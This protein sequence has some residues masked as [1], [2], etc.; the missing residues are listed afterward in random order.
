MKKIK[1]S[2][3]TVLIILMIGLFGGLLVRVFRLQI[4]HGS[5]YV[6]NFHL[7][8]KREIVLKGT[9]GNIY[10]RNGNPLARNE[11]AYAVTF[12]D[13]EKYASNRKRQIG[14]NGK[15]YQV[16]QLVKEKGNQVENNL[17]ITVD[18]NGEYQFLVQGT[19]L[20]RFKADIYGRSKIE[21][22]KENEKNATP[23]EMINYLC[24]E[25]KFSLFSESGKE[26]TS[27]ERA[28]YGLPEELTK[29]EV[30]DI[31]SLR[32]A[33]FLQAYQKYLPVTVA[34]NVSEETVAAVLE[35]QAEL[36]GVNVAEDSVRVYEG[37]ESMAPILGYTMNTTVGKAGLEQYLDEELQ[38][39]DGKQEVYVD[40]MGRVT[41]DAG[42]TKEPKSGKD[43]YLSI[44]V[45][46]QN[47]VYDALEKRI[48]EV[49]LA[50]LVN[51]RSFDKTAVSDTTEL[52]IPIYDVYVSLLTN[53]VVD[54][55]H[56][57]EED[58][59]ERE[60]NVYEAFQS[61]KE[62]VLTRIR[63]ELLENGT[64]YEEL[65]EEMQAYAAYI[66]RQADIFSTENVDTSAVSL[67]EFLKGAIQEK[68]IDLEKLDAEEA[69][70][71][72]EEVYQLTAEHILDW[73]SRQYEFDKL[74]YE[75]M[76]RKDEITPAEVCML[77]YEQ[78]IL[79]REEDF[80]LWQRG[81]ISTYELI[82]RKIEKSE[83]T[84]A[85][86]ALDP[87]SG[88]AIVTD[89]K[90]GK[91]LACVSYP[92]Y[93]NNRLAN[94]MDVDYYYKMYYNKSLPLY[95]R[96]TQQLSAPGS[97]FKPITVI[98]GMEEGVIDF[99]TSVMCD[100]VFDKVTPSLRC[101][102]HAGHGMV[103]NAADALRHSCNDYLCEI[104]YRLGMKGNTQFSDQ[105][106][107]QTIQTYASMFDLDK[108]TGI[109]LT[110]SSPQVT[111]QYAIPSAIGQGTNNFAT[112]QL[113]RYTN[114]LANRGI[115]YQLS[116]IERIADEKQE[117]KIESEIE[118][119]ETIWNSVQEGME[120]YAKST[121]TFDGFPI[122]V[123]GKS[124][125]AQ[126]VKT[127]PDHGLFIGYAPAENP[128][129]SVAVRIVNGYTAGSAVNCS[130]D[131]FEAYFKQD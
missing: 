94:Q 120:K 126:E 82:V 115:S 56:F 12:E 128:E 60:R 30:L 38:G 64:K 106:A 87:C 59:T 72:Q 5:E 19:A 99:S 18:R 112:V 7:K 129:I 107:L 78:G 41:Y 127:R 35:S 104:S 6:K 76:V 117:A 49:L 89:T 11:L 111:D 16:T 119:S 116:L 130:K 70:L 24:G 47:Q 27:E 91:V 86:L 39:K 15:I 125:T 53:E 95:N 97:T 65:S 101:W 22:L 52:R 40:N 109:E 17:E 54:L 42:I 74:I 124:G 26:Y 2:R 46:L 118:L 55:S 14:L 121:G 84:P 80:E 131:I 83:I 31:L 73:L 10:D 88:S 96:A 68:W 122:A 93:D 110:E 100:G 105:Q 67:K 48:T 85:D 102:N 20:E 44:D 23:D 3:L 9:R 62:V 29:E 28:E 103:T 113:G 58:A 81:A 51:T 69:Y 33:L 75:Y 37:G 79:E 43:V 90:T 8:T 34:R 114:T 1:I 108:K 25:E 36:S 98:A 77:L 63:E 21:E 66:V 50:N 92:G 57:E 32:Y 61:K 71:Q 123:A 13:S 45:N 4:V